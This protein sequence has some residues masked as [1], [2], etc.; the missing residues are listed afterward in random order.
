MISRHFHT[1]LLCAF[2]IIWYTPFT[3]GTRQTFRLDVPN[4]LNR[5]S[6]YSRNAPA[7]RTPSNTPIA[8]LNTAARGKRDVGYGCKSLGT[9]YSGA[10][11]HPRIDCAY[12]E[13]ADCKKLIT[14]FLVSEYWKGDKKSVDFPRGKLALSVYCVNPGEK[15]PDSV[16]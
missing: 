5:D 7:Q 13:T 1:I 10:V 11:P 14:I 9:G 12:F 6:T 16:G 8:L 4:F 2:S 15:F 3:Q